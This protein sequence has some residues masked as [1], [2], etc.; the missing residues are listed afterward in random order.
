MRAQSCRV[1]EEHGL[2]GYK[3]R[4][5]E[6]DFPAEQLLELLSMH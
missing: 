6:H 2:A 5:A 1:L 4:W 3:D